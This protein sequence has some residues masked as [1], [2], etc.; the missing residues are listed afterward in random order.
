MAVLDDEGVNRELAETPGWERPERDA[1]EI[2]RTFAFDDFTEAM[3]FVNGV[4]ELA[5][6]ANH[7]PDIT[8]RWNKVAL[9]LSTHSAGGLTGKDFA[10]A[11][12]INAL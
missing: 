2:V 10:L 11:R 1:G 8:I 6:D 4:A 12:R 7:H 9:S 3:G 5:E